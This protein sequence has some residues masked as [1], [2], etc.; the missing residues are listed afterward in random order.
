MRNKNSSTWNVAKKPTKKK[1]V[2][3]ESQ[4]LYNLE[5]VEKH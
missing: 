2:E 1:N 4:T 3:N 5:Y